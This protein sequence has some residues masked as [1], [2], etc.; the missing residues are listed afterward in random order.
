MKYIN[1][2]NLEKYNPGYKDRS[3]IW[4]KIYFNMINA[5]PDFEML[6]EIDRWR[7]IAFIMLQIQ[8]KKPTPIIEAYLSRKGFD[9]KKRSISKT[10][11]CLSN[12]IEVS[13]NSNVTEEFEVRNNSV[14]QSRVDKSR[15]EKIEIPPPY[16][17]LRAY[18]KERGNKIDPEKFWDFY[19]SKGWLVGKTC[20]KDWKAAVRTWEKTEKPQVAKRTTEE[21]QHPQEQSKEDQEKVSK[22]ISETVKKI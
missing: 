22:L 20:M 15:K 11:Q 4:C 5:D 13:E 18:C 21:Y 3:L 2:R 9:L 19:Q 17:L 7:F 16:E 12:L 1:V 6:E 8:S 14:T 10:V